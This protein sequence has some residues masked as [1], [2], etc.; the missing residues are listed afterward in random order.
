M[1][2]AAQQV[3]EWLTRRGDLETAFEVEGVLPPQLDTERDEDRA[4]LAEHDVDVD[5]LHSE[6][7]GS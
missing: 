2:V 7:A 6:L 4:L 1:L 3:V 5:A